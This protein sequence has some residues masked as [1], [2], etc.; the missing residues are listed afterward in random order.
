[1]H[2]AASVLAPRRAKRET[3]RV[4][5]LETATR[6][7]EREVPFVIVTLV[8]VRGH[9][10]RA[11]GAKM[12]VASDQVDGSIGGGNLEQTAIERAREMLQSRLVAP[13]LLSVSLTERAGGSYGVQCC[14]GEVTLMLEPIQS[15]RPQIVIF[16]AGHVGI[17]LTRA[18]SGLPVDIA[19][20]DSRM[21]MLEPSRLKNLSPIARLE[22][23]HEP[24]LYGLEQVF[25]S[26]RPGASLLVMTH[27]HLEDL[28]ILEAALRRPDLAY[29]GLIGSK[30]KWSTF[31]GQLRA[32]GFTNADLNRVTTPIGVNGVRGKQPEVIAIAVAAQLLM[33]LELP[34]P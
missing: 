9:A 17:A 25:E 22:T 19:L 16:G 28:A 1:M 18:L 34:E 13:E 32:K 20:I 7:R 2:F 21:D 23:R 3:E 24:V 29:I 14:G 10:P 27:D 5:W 4:S 15:A 30:A 31:T 8:I 33:H 11:P 26:I 12:I 6:W